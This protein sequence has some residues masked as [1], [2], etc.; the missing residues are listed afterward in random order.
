VNADKGFTLLEMLITLL[1][2]TIVLKAG[3]PAMQSLAR[4][5]QLTG[6]VSTY[7]HAFNSSRHT[8]MT[9]HRQIA[10]CVLDARN[11]CSGIWSN[12]LTLFYDDNRDG[13]LATPADII[14]RITLPAAGD[15][16]VSLRAFGTTKH[17]S[18]KANGHF[19]RNGT[20][21]FC[22]PESKRGKAIV[23]NVLGRARTEQIACPVR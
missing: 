6:M 23:I 7:L 9:A 19:R 14:E 21:R 3:V 16:T 1:A 22:S 11:R 17:I 8:A 2:I 5:A 20:F 15:I 13:A 4:D 18:M 10:M 12:D